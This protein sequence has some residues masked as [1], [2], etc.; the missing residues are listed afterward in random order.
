MWPQMA[1][2]HPAPC[3]LWSQRDTFQSYIQLPSIIVAFTTFIA[4]KYQIL[5]K[6]R[7][8][9]VPSASCQIC[10]VLWD[11][12]RECVA[13]LLQLP[14]WLHISGLN[15]YLPTTTFAC[16]SISLKG[17]YELLVTEV[18]TLS[19]TSNPLELLQ[20]LLRRHHWISPCSAGHDICEWRYNTVDWVIWYKA[21]V[22]C[23]Q[24]VELCDYGSPVVIFVIS[25]QISITNYLPSTLRRLKPLTWLMKK[26]M[27]FLYVICFW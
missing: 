7:H 21:A 22:E 23:I 8:R 5:S 17:T 26:Q 12:H 2:Y 27:T 9:K 3:Y 10:P 1:R 15:G 11:I 18:W 25:G 6:R 19:A 20:Y 24:L 14:D 4:I 13:N 16:V